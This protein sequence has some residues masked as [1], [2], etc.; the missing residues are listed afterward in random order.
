MTDPGA[1]DSG[2]DRVIATAFRRSLLAIAAG[3]AVF[4]AWYWWPGGT[5]TESGVSTP[6]VATP[7]AL[8]EAPT[9]KLTFSD[10][11]AESGVDFEFVTGARGERLLPE[12][13]VGGVA[14]LDFDNDGDQDLLLVGGNHWPWSGES[15]LDASVG[16]FANDGTGR[17][18]RVDRE[19]EL[20]TS[21]YGMGAAVGDYDG[22]G[23]LDI[24]I[25]ALG[26]NQ[27]FRNRSGVGFEDVTKSLG[28]A[29]DPKGWSTAATF[30]DA[31]GDGWLD[32]FVADYVEWDPELDRSVDYQLAGIGRAYG[33][34]TNF[35]GTQ[36]RLYRNLEGRE[37]EDITD[38][39]GVVVTSGGTAVAKSLAV[40]PVDLD[41]DGDTDLVVAN[42]TTRNF[43]Y[44]NQGDGRFVELGQQLG[45]AFD[46]MGN[47]TGAMGIDGA[48]LFGQSMTL[49]IGNFANEMT[50]VYSA[51]PGPSGE[52]GLWFADDAVL[53]GVGPASRGAL[54]FGLFFAD[55]DLDGRLDL[56]Q[57]N[58][59]VE[60]E[61]NQVQPSQFYQQPP[62]L[63]WNCGQGCERPYQ[64][65]AS[66]GD[67]ARPLVGRGA[68]YGD[69]DGDGD[70]DIVLAE[71]GGKARLYR[72]EVDGG[73]WLRV[74][75]RDRPPNSFAFGA[76]IH[77]IA[78][79]VRQSRQVTPTRSYLSQTEVIATF[80]LGQ[81]DTV[82]Q[83]IVL[84]PD[85]SR[86]S[87]A[88]VA[89]NQVLT[90]KRAQ[91]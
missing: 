5:D 60:N 6:V 81:A 54:T 70:L 21:R 66:T 16:L 42:D 53:T 30:F 73:N 77:L 20:T 45:L 37:F 14:V 90:V 63:F 23:F 75:L 10:V 34:P 44:L 46:N 17:F 15:P 1:W 12:T 88:R 47:A 2:D 9:P 52:D 86:Q 35:P 55:L 83:V 13:M 79:G 49:A 19:L 38:G 40:C 80:G 56:F 31:D 58:G 25:S 48:R 57:A 33:P 27:L 36:P 7:Q 11:T 72:N 89:A 29:G 64:L 3:L 24:F 74:R 87:L 50:S 78:G 84:W 91:Q 69:L 41:S 82:D 65:A 43:A 51:Q 8:S 71:A 59:H 76:E 32:L 39:S 22:D 26:G 67:L 61:I 28:V 85:G 18:R 4:M 68:A 62:Q